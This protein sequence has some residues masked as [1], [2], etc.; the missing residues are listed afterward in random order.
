MAKNPQSGDMGAW[1]RL[2]PAD[3]ASL[4]ELEKACFSLP[5]SLGQLRGAFS[6]KAFAAIGY[7]GPDGL[8]AYLSVYHAA[9]EVEI[10]N[11][12]VLPAMRRRG[13][14]RTLLL[15]ALQAASKMGMQ[16]AWLEVRATNAPAISLYESCRFC[17]AGIRPRYYPDTGED[18][19]VFCRDIKPAA[20]EL[21]DCR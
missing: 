13:I 17:R 1:R 4:W 10:L 20:G 6:Q 14:A 18:A 3:A 15:S 8:C 16:K 2:G 11:L 5:W 12:A 21:P 7:F 9:D 19:L